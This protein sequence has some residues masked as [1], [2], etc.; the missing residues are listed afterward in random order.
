MIRYFQS[1]YLSRYIVIFILAIVFWTPSFIVQTNSEEISLPFYQLLSWLAGNNYYILI[2]VAFSIIL[3]SSLIINYLCTEI[4]ISAKIS[5]LGSFLFIIVASA[6]TFYTEMSPFIWVNILLLLML[7][8]LYFFPASNNH[9]AD[10][11]N[12]GFLVG[13]A[14]LFF[15]QAIL[16]IFLIWMAFF[17][18]R[19]GSWR[20]YLVA[21][22]GAIMPHIF[23]LTWYFWNDRTDEF[24]NLWSNLF[25]YSGLSAFLQMTNMDSIILVVLVAL[26]IFSVLH[27]F[28]KLWKK[29]INLRRNLQ[30]TLY[31]FIFSVLI[32]LLTGKVNSFQLIVIPSSII[33]VHSF[34]E[35]KRGRLVNILLTV[36][37]GLIIVNQ[38]LKLIVLF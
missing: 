22:I 18:H 5:M 15:T 37:I 17:I 24:I 31:F 20:N 26:V 21:L 33:L 4:G 32:I 14:S 35:L 34:N 1:G 11:F 30:I 8:L 6:L 28:S 3:F 10:S 7:R 13:V 2:S 12:A 38:F 25:D 9:I 36:F 29:S 23:A 19:S 16:F 27:S